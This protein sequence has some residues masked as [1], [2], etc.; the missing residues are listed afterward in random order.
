MEGAD[1]VLG[2][3][4][5]DFDEAVVYLGGARRVEGVCVEV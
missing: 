4:V 3:A 2:G 5:G 1:E